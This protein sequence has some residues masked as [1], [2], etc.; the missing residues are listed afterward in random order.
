MPSCTTVD[1]VLFTTSVKAENAG[2]ASISLTGVDVIGEG[3]SVG[4]ASISGNYAI[5]A[6]STPP[7]T[8]NVGK[9]SLSFTLL[10][11]GDPTLPS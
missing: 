6:V 5:N 9:V 11:M 7:P 8:D 3:A 2:T 10:V 4:S 1:K